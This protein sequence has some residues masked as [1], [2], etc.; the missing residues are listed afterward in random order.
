MDTST[1][2]VPYTFVSVFAFSTPWQ[3]FF[4]R[5]LLQT[6]YVCGLLLL[7]DVQNRNNDDVY[8]KNL[9]PKL[10]PQ[11]FYCAQCHDPVVFMYVAY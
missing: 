5:M 7:S 8:P 6:V 3:K 2:T 10:V 4:L 9:Q 11:D 1:Y